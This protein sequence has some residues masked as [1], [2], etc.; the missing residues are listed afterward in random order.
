MTS[1]VL[2]LQHEATDST[3]RVDDLLRKAV[4][5]ATTLGIEDFRAWAAK[6]LQGYA[7]DSTTPP[8]RRVTGVLRVFHARRG[9]IPVI[10]P[11]KDLQKKLESRAAGEPISELEDLYHDP[12]KGDLLQ[13]AP[14]PDDEKLTF[15]DL[16]ELVPYHWVLR[17][18]GDT[19][20]FQ[21][22]TTPTLM[23]NRS[24]IKG[25]LDAVRNEVLQWSVALEGQGMITDPPSRPR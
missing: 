15:E 7:G 8:Y 22:G 2:E 16:M 12:V 21:P 9:W 6:E 4:E 13:V 19:R 24:T 14:G 3:V 20:E 10:L 11:D 23:I 18:F 1:L 17:I 5:V 25:I